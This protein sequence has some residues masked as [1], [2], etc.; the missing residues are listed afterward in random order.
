MLEELLGNTSLD[1]LDEALL[2]LDDEISG[3]N[4]IGNKTNYLNKLG[5]LYSISYIKKYINNYIEINKNHFS[6]IYVW[7]DINNVL[8]RKDNKLR[9]MVK[10]YIL[11]IYSKQFNN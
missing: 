4:K 3:N 2:F 8:Y 6:E 11:K 5:K 1:Y 7:E 10:Y 9:R